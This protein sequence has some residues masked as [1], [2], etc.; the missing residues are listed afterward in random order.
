MESKTDPG[1][2]IPILNPVQKRTT[3]STTKTVLS[4]PLSNHTDLTLQVVDPRRLQST[5]GTTSRTRYPFVLVTIRLV[6]NLSDRQ[7]F[8]FSYSSSALSNLSLM[9]L[10]DYPVYNEILTKL[11]INELYSETSIEPCETTQP[12]HGF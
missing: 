5:V 8:I 10:Q 11:I 2:K 12:Q 3:R 7:P 9:Q 1:R 4:E 6:V